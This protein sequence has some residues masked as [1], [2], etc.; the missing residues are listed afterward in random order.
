MQNDAY[1]V[2]L[3]GGSGTRFW[4]AS[5]KARPKQILP[6][7]PNKEAPL[8]A[9]TVRRIESLVS[10]DHV[11]VATN[12][13]LVDATRAALPR[14][15]ADAFLGEP[16]ARNTAACI[17]WATGIVARRNPEAIVMVLPSDHHIADEPAFRDVLA[18]AL[19]SAAGGVITTVGIAPTRPDTGYG[20]IELGEEL[21]PGL[22]RGLR[23]VE[24]PDRPR[25]EEYLAS[26]RFVWNSGMF[27]FRARQMLEAIRAHLPALADGIERIEAAARRG[28]S[29]ER[30]ETESVFS[31]V[32][33]VS[34]DVGVMEKVERLH[35]IP[36]SFGWS[37]LGS[38]ESAWE[39]ADKDDAGN[40]SNGTAV[41]V[42][43]KRNLV[44]DL[45]TSGPKRVMAAVGVDDLC[46]VETDDALLV[47]PRSRSQD[48][49][50]VVEELTRRGE[51][52]KL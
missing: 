27:F 4:P 41:L 50:A 25:A 37:D 11:L 17:G 52:E 5:R 26:G 29:Q 20:Y 47:I 8:I 21:A 46:I 49:R 51:A 40:A 38:W 3:A 22:R 28:A 19:A 43:A 30:A 12:K 33:S 6:L 31:T 42:D 32:P 36:G 10:A 15:P 24:K 13:N 44:L 16:V 45:R 1:A 39:L 9:E 7:G 34:I 48:V 23:F 2:I 18:R 35:V 14:L